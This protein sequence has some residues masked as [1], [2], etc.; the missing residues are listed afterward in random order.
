MYKITPKPGKINKKY[1]ILYKE[2]PCF[3]GEETIIM[4]TPE[5]VGFKEGG[6]TH[7]KKEKMD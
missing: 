3:C 1:A 5:N 6:F 4:G 7:E 2:N